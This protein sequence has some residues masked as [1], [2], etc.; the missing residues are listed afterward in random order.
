MQQSF[1]V[2]M[3]HICSMLQLS[4]SG[5]LR[6]ACREKVGR[7]LCKSDSPADV[8]MLEAVSLI[9]GERIPHLC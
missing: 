1:N 6:L 3:N 2:V 9:S 4:F 8:F 7:R 5:D